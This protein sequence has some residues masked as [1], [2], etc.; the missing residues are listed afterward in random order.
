MDVIGEDPKMQEM[1]QKYDKDKSNLIQILNEVQEYYGYVP[2][3]SQLAIS[4]Y[5]SIPMAEIYGVVTFYSRF[6]LKPKGKYHIAVCLGTACFVKGS[7]K[8]L[9]RVKERLGIDV[10]ETTKDG[11]FSLEATRC[12]GACGLAPVFTVNDEVYGKATV[13]MI[14]EILD[15]YMEN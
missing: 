13:K 11:K 4:E 7:E 2:E 12:V 10:G 1:L 6:T 9:D 8:I 3:K 5:L 15:K 14:D